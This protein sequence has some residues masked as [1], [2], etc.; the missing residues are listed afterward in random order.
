MPITISSKYEASYVA[1]ARVD[2][3]IAIATAIFA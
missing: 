3:L 1:L 2:E